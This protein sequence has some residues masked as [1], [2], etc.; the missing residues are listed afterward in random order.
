LRLV[1]G[2]TGLLQPRVERPVES[3]ACGLALPPAF[4]VI[5]RRAEPMDR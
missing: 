3:R 4:A 1:P 2:R 5:A